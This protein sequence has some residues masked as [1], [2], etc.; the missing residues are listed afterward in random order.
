METLQVDGGNTTIPA[1]QFLFV[2]EAA[3]LCRMSIWAVYREVRAG[4]MPSIRSSTGRIMFDR[5]QLLAWMQS[6]T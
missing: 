5:T 6:G 4:R 1:H 3:T 2:D